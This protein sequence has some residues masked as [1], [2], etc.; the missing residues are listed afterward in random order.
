MGDLLSEGLILPALVLGLVGFV[1]PR[2]LARMLPEGVTPLMINGFVSTAVTFVLAS[3][4]FYL[5]YLWQ[6]APLDRLGGA[7]P[8]ALVFHFGSLGLAS[9][10]IWAPVMI[11]SWAGLPRRWVHETW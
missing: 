2:L 1:I 5:L 6:G 10:L 7:G 3:C 11:L 8:G 4:F 9:A